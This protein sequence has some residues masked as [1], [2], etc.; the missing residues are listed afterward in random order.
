LGPGQLEREIAQRSEDA[1]RRPDAV[2]G[3]ALDV[4]AID[5]DQSELTRDEEAG[6]ED[7]NDDRGQPQEGANGLAPGSRFEQG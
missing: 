2:L 6:E 1:P 3:L 7:E 4:A 5:C